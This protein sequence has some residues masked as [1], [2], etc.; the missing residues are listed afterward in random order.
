ME[1]PYTGNFETQFISSSFLLWKPFDVRKSISTTSLK[2]CKNIFLIYSNENKFF[3]Y[4]K[5]YSN[6]VYKSFFSNFPYQASRWKTLKKNAVHI[7]NLVCFCLD[8]NV[9]IGNPDLEF[10]WQQKDSNTGAPY[11]DCWA[12][13]HRGDSS[14]HSPL[15]TQSELSNNLE[16]ALGVIENS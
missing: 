14:S 13:M 1:L 7:K 15:W 6:I 12:V 8:H 4:S 10:P 5:M 3:I 11:P 9:S 16:K 2:F